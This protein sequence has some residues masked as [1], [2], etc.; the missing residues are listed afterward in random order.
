MDVIY[1]ARLA[2]KVRSRDAYIF[3]LTSLQKDACPGV[4]FIAWFP[5]ADALSHLLDHS[6]YVCSHHK[7]EGIVEIRM[8]VPLPDGDIEE[9]DTR[10]MDPEQDFSCARRR[11]GRLFHPEDI[12]SAITVNTNCFHG[13]T[14]LFHAGNQSV[15]L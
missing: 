11:A 15:G 3:R 14:L 10:S 4:D 9:V 1:R 5:A 7:R 6:R 12:R 13:C 2:G 8:Q